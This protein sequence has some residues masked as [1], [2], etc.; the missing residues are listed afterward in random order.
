MT[1][2]HVPGSHVGRMHTNRKEEK[3]ECF[4]VQRVHKEFLYLL[5]PSP[6]R[7]ALQQI[8]T[9]RSALCLR[10]IVRERGHV[11]RNS[12]NRDSVSGSDFLMLLCTTSAQRLYTHRRNAGGGKRP[13]GTTWCPRTCQGAA[14]WT[15]CPVKSTWS[16]VWSSGS[17]GGGGSSE[18]VALGLER[19]RNWALVRWVGE[20]HQPRITPSSNRWRI[21][22]VGV[23][24]TH[25]HART[26]TTQHKTKHHNELRY[27]LYFIIAKAGSVFNHR[28]FNVR[29]G[30]RS[31]EQLNTEHFTIHLPSK[32]LLS[33]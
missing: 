30:T 8:A 13:P 28:E 26:N 25:T 31:G 33:Y 24:G 11:M 32:S 10:R 29:A 6:L 15:G 1:P 27:E 21:Q 18:A 14:P 19:T 23:R 17:S 5:N 2:P 3:N 7:A 4:S 20:Q 12:T 22:H 16:R 9:S